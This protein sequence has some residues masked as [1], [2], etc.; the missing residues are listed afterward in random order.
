M[1]RVKTHNEAQPGLTAEHEE[2]STE[3]HLAELLSEM[4]CQSTAVMDV[5]MAEYEE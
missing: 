1:T 2:E 4:Y 5:Q 3:T